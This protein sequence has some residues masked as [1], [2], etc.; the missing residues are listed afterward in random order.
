[1]FF[2]RRYRIIFHLISIGIFY[3]DFWFLATETLDYFITHIIILA[4]AY[5]WSEFIINYLGID[6]D[7]E[8][9]IKDIEKERSKNNSD[10]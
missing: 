2:L 4:G 10:N 5:F 3:L 7:F 1:M 6:K 8:E 9:I